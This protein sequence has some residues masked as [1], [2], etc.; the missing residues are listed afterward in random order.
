[1]WSAFNSTILFYSVNHLSVK[2]SSRTKHCH[3]I[4]RCR[5]EQ[6]PSPQTE[7]RNM[8]NQVSEK[9]LDTHMVC[10]K[11]THTT[12]ADRARPNPQSGDRS[13]A[14]ATEEQ[15]ALWHSWRGSS[16][17][18]RA[19]F[20][21]TSSRRPARPA[22][23]R[24]LRENWLHCHSP[25]R[26]RTK[27]RHTAVDHSPSLTTYINIQLLDWLNQTHATMPTAQK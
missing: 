6:S 21:R 27:P 9:L 8:Q 26:S 2:Q 16:R 12:E 18:G 19:R 4:Q 24:L 7:Y 20:P 22:R 11:N 13:S 10:K 3:A 5:L 23:W 15:R 17:C 25:R 14:K 1:M